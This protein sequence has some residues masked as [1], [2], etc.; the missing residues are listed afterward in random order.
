[1]KKPERPAEDP[2]RTLTNGGEDATRVVTPPSKPKGDGET[3]G[4]AAA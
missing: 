2:T 1:M 3:G 4:G